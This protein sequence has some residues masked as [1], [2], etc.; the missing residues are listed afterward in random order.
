MTRGASRDRV[1]ARLAQLRGVYEGFDIQQTTLGVGPEEF[2]R[3]CGEGNSAVRA[4][5]TVT[6]P[7]GRHLLVETADGW[8]L[9][10]TDVSAGEPITETLREA[11][12]RQTGLE[13]VIE[14]VE[15]AAIVAIDCEATGESTYQLQV[16]FAATPGEGTLDEAAAWR[17]EPTEVFRSR[18]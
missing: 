10:G 9:P 2:E 18:L 16:R 6:D 8:S 12:A 1:T 4:E 5:V 13:P 7:R 17:A 3:V 15:A 11:V 14:T